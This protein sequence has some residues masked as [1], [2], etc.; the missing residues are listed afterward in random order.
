MKVKDLIAALQQVPQ[1]LDVIVFLPDTA[2]VLGIQVFGQGENR[3]VAIDHD[4]YIGPTPDVV[5]MRD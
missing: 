5:D 1:D 3:V 2:N 4:I